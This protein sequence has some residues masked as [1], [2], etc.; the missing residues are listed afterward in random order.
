ML[1]FQF[2]IM[3]RIF[4]LTILMIVFIFYSCDKDETPVIES[5]DVVLKVATTNNITIT[6]T[7]PN[8]KVITIQVPAEAVESIIANSEKLP[9]SPQGT[10]LFMNKD[11]P[12]NTYDVF[13][14]SYDGDKFIGTFGYPSGGNYE[15]TGDV[16]G[17]IGSIDSWGFQRFTGKFGIGDKAIPLEVATSESDGI[18]KNWRI[19][20]P[21]QFL[22][23]TTEPYSPEGYYLIGEF[24]DGVENPDYRFYTWITSIDGNNFKGIYVSTNSKGGDEVQ[25]PL[26]GSIG[27]TKDEFAPL[28]MALYAE[29]EGGLIVYKTITGTVHISDGLRGLDSPFKFIPTLVVD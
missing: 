12:Y 8:G 26:E 19:K 5:E 21:N 9:Y 3:K 6:K 11:E 24:Q 10:Y 14:T 7:L 18:I 15:Y 27:L 20:K 4:S 1:K 25:G 23:L 16:T 2:F 22:V 17:G 13:I 29:T 28:T